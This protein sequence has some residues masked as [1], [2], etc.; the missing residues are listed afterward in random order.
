[1]LSSIFDRIQKNQISLKE[2]DMAREKHVAEPQ[3][4]NVV[5]SFFSDPSNEVEKK[6]ATQFS[7]ER[8]LLVKETEFFFRQRRR[9]NPNSSSAGGN[10]SNFFV[11]SPNNSDEFVGPMFSVAGAPC[12]TVFAIAMESSNG[13]DKKKVSE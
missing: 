3:T 7:K 8:D 9:P 5:G 4:S 6:R 13:T 10:N 1:M 2:D 11:R 12:H